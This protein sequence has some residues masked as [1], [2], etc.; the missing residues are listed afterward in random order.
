MAVAE[1]AD[2]CSNGTDGQVTGRPPSTY[3]DVPWG[4]VCFQE[5]L[6]RSFG[7]LTT[8]NE[9][10]I[11]KALQITTHGHPQVQKM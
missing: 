11:M 10:V 4:I 9:L 5:D 1:V 7:S 6:A 2:W 8:T 3:L